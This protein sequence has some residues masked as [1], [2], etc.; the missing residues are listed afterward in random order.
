M[1]DYSED[2]D[3]LDQALYDAHTTPDFRVVVGALLLLARMLS[4]IGQELTAIHEL[5]RDTTSIQT[6]R[7]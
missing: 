6:A 1:R 2:L 3:A 5:L 7:G 4:D